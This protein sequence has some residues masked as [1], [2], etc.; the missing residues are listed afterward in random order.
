M[1]DL[2]LTQLFYIQLFCSLFMTGLI[3]FVQ[4]VHYP[5][6]SY[7]EPHCFPDYAKK[8]QWLTSWVVGPIMLT[9]VFSAI[10][11]F[12]QHRFFLLNIM[13]LTG[14]WL[15]TAILQIPLHGRLAEHYDLENI[16]SLVRGNWIRTI[17]WTLKSI[18]LIFSF[19]DF[20]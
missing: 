10:V 4:I 9:E 17:L 1:L 19:V 12:I 14:I 11:L 20:G 13:L 15:S 7:I 3:W 8:H 2:S 6:F 16:H 5:L 18:V